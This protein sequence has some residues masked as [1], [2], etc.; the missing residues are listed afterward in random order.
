MQKKYTFK[1][2]FL[3]VQQCHF[4]L[5]QTRAEKDSRDVFDTFSTHAALAYDATDTECCIHGLFSCVYNVDFSRAEREIECKT[6]IYKSL[7]HS[8]L[9]IGPMIFLRLRS[10]LSKMD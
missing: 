4:P 7:L 1:L 3:M 5:Y 2:Y 8:F 10:P 6:H 9:S